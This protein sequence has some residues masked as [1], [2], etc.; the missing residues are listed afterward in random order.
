M[1][2]KI[3]PPSNN[4]TTPLHHIEGISILSQHILESYRYANDGLQVCRIR[5]LCM[6]LTQTSLALTQ[7][8]KIQAVK[9]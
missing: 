8:K 3:N 2:F 7:L 5:L 6:A 4:T 1:E 9:D